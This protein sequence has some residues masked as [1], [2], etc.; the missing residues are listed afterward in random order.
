MSQIKFVI[1]LVFLRRGYLI[2]IFAVMLKWSLSR[3]D[4]AVRNGQ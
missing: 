4:V 1:I 3:V 2:V